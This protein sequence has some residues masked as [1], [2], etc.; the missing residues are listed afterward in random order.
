MER[1]Q[2][3]APVQGSGQGIT[4]NFPSY[5]SLR[6]LQLR[7]LPRSDSHDGFPAAE[8]E[9]FPK[10]PKSHLLSS[11]LLRLFAVFGFLKKAANEEEFLP[12]LR[13]LLPSSLG[14]L[15]SPCSDASPRPTHPAAHGGGSSHHPSASKS[16]L[17]WN[18]PVAIRCNQ[19]PAFF[20]RWAFIGFI[21]M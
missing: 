10:G 6:G 11:L 21:G 3:W 13:F 7:S 2:S 1:G 19:T 17:L 14:N 12:T 4:L 15:P 20:L 8:I 5:T 18:H 9:S 16:L